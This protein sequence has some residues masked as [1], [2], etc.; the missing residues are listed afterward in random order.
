[1]QNYRKPTTSFILSLIG[2]AIVFITGI[3]GLAWFG[4]NGPNWGGFGGWRSGMMSGYHNFVGAG[5]YSFFS[6]IS[7]LGVFSGAAIIAGAIMLRIRPQDHLIWGIL[8]LVFAL[9]S[10]V[11]MGGYFVGALLGIIGG[12]FAISYQPRTSQNQTIAE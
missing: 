5:Q 10:F 2:G 4:Q 9:V 3:V 6:I 1:M 12:A 7:L 11:D 8:I